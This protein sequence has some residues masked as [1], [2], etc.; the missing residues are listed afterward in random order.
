MEN[1]YI[2]DLNVFIGEP[3]SNGVLPC[4]I[5]IYVVMS[6]HLLILGMNQY[7]SIVQE[8]EQFIG[9]G[10]EGTTLNGFTLQTAMKGKQ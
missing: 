5:I 4:G 8:T 9:I 1:K 10:T 7:K 6:K 3:V 2:L